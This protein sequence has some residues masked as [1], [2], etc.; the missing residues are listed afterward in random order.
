MRIQSAS[1]F[2]VSV[3]FLLSIAF[4]TAALTAGVN[5]PPP[6]L[7]IN[8]IDYDQPGTDNAEFI[9]IMNSGYVD[10]YLDAYTLVLINGA[11]GSAVIY[12]TIDLPGVT[13]LPGEYLV[14][15][16]NSSTVANCDLDASPEESFI[17]NGAPDAVALMYATTLIDTVSY[18]GDTISP[19]TEGTGAGL[20]DNPDIANKG[21]SRCP[22][23][24]DSGQ[25]NQDFVYTDITP[26]EMNDC[27]FYM[28]YIPAIL[29]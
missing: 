2:I 25:N 8:E 4:S 19:Y 17:Q 5:I 11:S 9:E 26:G 6:N 7:I 10:A 21:I 29:Y 27:Y 15:C 18:E 16:A 24:N 28:L 20:E 22:D 13:L 1:R 12:Q 23:G 14:V 3:C